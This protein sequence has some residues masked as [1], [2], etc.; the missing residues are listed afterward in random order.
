[1]GQICVK[2]PLSEFASLVMKC[3]QQVRP[4]AAPRPVDELIHSQR[5]ARLVRVLFHRRRLF[6]CADTRG[7][8]HFRAM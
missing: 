1:M 6:E 2:H 7:H 4:H 5:Q 3:L 8:L